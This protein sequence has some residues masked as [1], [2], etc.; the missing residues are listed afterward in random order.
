MGLNGSELC[1]S[2][3]GA[4]SDDAGTSLPTFVHN[5]TIE[6]IPSE[7]GHMARRCLVDLIA[8]WAAGAD[9]EPSRIARD[10]AVRRYRGDIPLPFDGRFANPIGVAFAGAA[11]IDSID[12]HDGHQPSKGHAGV[13]LLPALFAELGPDPLCSTDE[14]LAHLIVGYEV[15]IRAA[16]S[17]HST[18]PD[19]HSSGAW[20]ALG[21]TAIAARLRGFTHEQTRHALGIAEYFGPRAQMMRCIEHPSMVKDSSSW[22]PLVGLSAAD[23]AEDGFTGAPAITCEGEDVTPLWGDLGKRWRILET[24]FKAHP[25]C[26]WAHPP[27][28]AAADLR[29]QHDIALNDIDEILVTSFHEATQLTTMR[30]KDSDAAQYSL[31]VIVALGLVHETILPVHLEPDSYDRPDFWRLVDGVRFAESDAYNA[32]FPADRCADVTFTLSDGRT[33]RSDTFLAQ[34]NF[35][36]PLP[37][38]EILQKLDAYTVPVFSD[39]TRNKVGLYLT[40]PESAPSP[41]DLLALLHVHR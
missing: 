16:L 3:V 22:G 8:V 33:V 4:K 6:D 18:V 27:L 15:A 1:A 32:R 11:A 19:Y 24:N 40:D 30:P 7:V 2:D 34:G 37:D 17:L 26:R 41:K 39:D 14:M 25:V 38:S 12:A 10:H 36:Q 28:E 21:C 23:L 13:A 20:N 9:T 29:K 31:P 5:L 35:D